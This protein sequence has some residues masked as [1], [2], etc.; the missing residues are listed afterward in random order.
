[1]PVT[2]LHKMASGLRSGQR[3]M[4]LDLGSKTIGLALSDVMRT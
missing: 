1:M 4:G 3:L 2:D